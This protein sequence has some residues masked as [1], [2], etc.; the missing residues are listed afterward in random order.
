MV[1][2][3]TE[4]Q[5][6]IKRIENLE[7]QLKTPKILTKTIGISTEINHENLSQRKDLIEFIFKNEGKPVFFTSIL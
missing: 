1:L 5:E 7:F 2:I 6:L 4:N 3:R